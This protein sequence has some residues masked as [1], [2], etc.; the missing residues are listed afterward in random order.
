MPALG[1]GLGLSWRSC[2]AQKKIV[3]RKGHAA[4]Q[5]GMDIDS[6]VIVTGLGDDHTAVREALTSAAKLVLGPAAVV[7]DP[8]VPPAIGFDLVLLVPTAVSAAVLAQL[9]E[10]L[11]LELHR[12]EVMAAE[13]AVE[14][15]PE[16]DA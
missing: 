14:L 3:E 10:A 15:L 6:L 8:V 16:A 2:R 13:L 4:L 12:R 5:L 9:R 7:I 1:M 11:V